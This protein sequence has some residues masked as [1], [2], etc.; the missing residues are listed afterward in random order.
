MAEDDIN[1]GDI[2]NATGR[3]ENSI[4][5]S[6]SELASTI[7]AT[8]ANINASIQGVSQALNKE[9]LQL[10]ALQERVSEDI[11]NMGDYFKSIIS[12]LSNLNNTVLEFATR[13]DNKVGLSEKTDKKEETSNKKSSVNETLTDLKIN[14]SA[15]TAQEIGTATT[16]ADITGTGFSVLA[17]ILTDMSGNVMARLDQLTQALVASKVPLTQS[18]QTQ[19]AGT[20]SKEGEQ[21]KKSALSDFFTQL[22]GPVNTIASGLL[23]LSVA[24]VIL[25]T[26]GLSPGLIQGMLLFGASL[27]A[28]FFVLKQLSTYYQAEMVPIMDEESKN[29][30][31][32]ILHIIQSFSL[33]ILSINASILLSVATAQMVQNNLGT[34]CMGLLITFGSMIMSLFA[35]SALSQMGSPVVAKDS[36]VMQLVNGFTRMI[37]TIAL[38]SLFCAITWPYMMEG[39]GHAFK[40]ITFTELTIGAM[41]LMARK[42]SSVNKD[43]LD[44]FQSLLTT[45]IVLIGVLSILTIVL[46]IIPEAIIQQGVI[47]ITLL[48]GMT[49]ALIGM[50]TFG[51][52]KIQKVPAEQIWAFMG[53]L[54]ASIAC[55]TILS[56]LTIILAQ[57]DLPAIYAALGCLVVISAIP[58]VLFKLMGRIGNQSGSLPKALLGTVIAAALTIAVAGV[59]NLII[60]ILGVFTLA[61][62]ITT[63]VAISAVSLLMIGMSLFIA[64]MGGMWTGPL[65]GF[66]PSALLGIAMTSLIALAVAGA[67]VGV[68]AALSTV[69]LPGMLQ[70]VKTIATIALLFVAISGTVVLL[71]AMAP[72]LLV[73]TALALYSVGRIIKFIT[74]ASEKIKELNEAAT[75]SSTVD[76]T[77]IQSIRSTIKSLLGIANLIN[78]LAKLAPSM[79]VASIAALITIGSTMMV[80]NNLKTNLSQLNDLS[81]LEFGEN[82]PIQIV[83]ES[84]QYLGDLTKAINKL[85]V[86]NPLKVV[87]AFAT[88]TAAKSI[89]SRLSKLGSAEKTQKIQY[90]TNSLARLA[91]QQQSLNGLAAAIQNVAKATETLNQVQAA[92]VNTMNKGI[93]R[94]T[95]STSLD[96]QNIYQSKSNTTVQS[97]GIDMN[98][99]EDALGEMIGLLR[100]IKVA[101]FENLDQSQEN[102]QAITSSANMRVSLAD[103]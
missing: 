57:Q 17:N 92:N 20:E 5:Q 26:M 89:E 67:A 18:R 84:V 94:M 65:L 43:V 93:E 42:L 45:V 29:E 35:L 36:P 87:S 39:F 6:S 23:L 78:P 102:N 11:N 95:G 58:L 64:L 75:E 91:S 96:V 101:S 38:F 79:V 4:N 77:A 103:V 86:V 21:G 1:R 41:I 72:L 80:V 62:V 24:T 69:D 37:I 28:T 7:N 82:N 3:V 16:L 49:L 61:Q 76:E 27:F 59:A 47:T 97:S 44:S 66:V 13:P 22:A 63:T 25:G 68:T 55:I 2:N 99:I 32:N 15:K 51:I 88:L 19:G 50:V 53:V 52:K 98:K 48:T 9:G 100:E 71:G 54:I 83:Q 14:T 74:G 33:M 30:P 60:S 34:L 8:N 70:T 46:G 12:Y 73:G 90:L 10:T 40:I 85:P 56:V 31:S 81:G